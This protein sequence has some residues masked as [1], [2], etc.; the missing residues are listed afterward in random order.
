M[1][2]AVIASMAAE[3]R[4]K[5]KAAM[6]SAIGLILIGQLLLGESPHMLWSLRNENDRKLVMR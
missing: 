2:M 5:M 3:K 1:E 6:I 4:G